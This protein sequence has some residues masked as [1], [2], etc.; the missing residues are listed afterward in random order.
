[1]STAPDEATPAA[2]Q[3]EPAEPAV[4]PAPRA[5]ETPA[6]ER[7]EA[8]VQTSGP[9]FPQVR[10]LVPAG[11]QEKK[12]VFTFKPGEGFRELTAE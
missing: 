6:S 11:K 7:D 2:A 10:E 9:N 1:M 12:R 5:P 3:T 8:P 4:S